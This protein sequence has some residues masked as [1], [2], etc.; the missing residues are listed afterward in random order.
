VPSV[1]W[2]TRQGGFP[3]ATRLVQAPFAYGVH[4]GLSV[5]GILNAVRVV[6]DVVLLPEVRLELI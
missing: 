6:V 4:H 3:Q 5:H 1:R 2:Q